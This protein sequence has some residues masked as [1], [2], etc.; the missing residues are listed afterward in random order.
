MTHEIQENE[1]R[2]DRG[3]R[4]F[5]RISRVI[6]PRAAR[7]ATRR[8]ADHSRRNNVPSVRLCVSSA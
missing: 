8:S 6:P 4:S 2:V 5:S 3:G 7:R 1:R